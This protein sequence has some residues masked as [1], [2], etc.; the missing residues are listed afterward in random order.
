MAIHHLP[1]RHYKID[2]QSRWGPALYS[3]VGAGAGIVCE[4][5][6][7]TTIITSSNVLS[8]F[9]QGVGVDVVYSGWSGHTVYLTAQM[10]RHLI[11]GGASG[12]YPLQEAS[13]NTDLS[14]IRF[15]VVAQ[16]R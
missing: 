10:S 15:H 3:A 2:H 5:S 8:I 4:M 11:S 1:Q 9:A 16:G 7:L 6:G 12:Y 14:D 13:A